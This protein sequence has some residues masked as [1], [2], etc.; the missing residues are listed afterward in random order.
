VA[1]IAKRPLLLIGTY[2]LYGSE[3]C[4]AHGRI[5][6]IVLNQ[7]ALLVRGLSRSMDVLLRRS[8]IAVDWGKT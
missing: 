8:H 7:A 1:R 5:V 4:N 2:F 3:V 6:R